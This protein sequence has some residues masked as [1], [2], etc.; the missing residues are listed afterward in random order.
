MDQVVLALGQ[1]RIVAVLLLAVRLS[2]VLLLT[3]VLHAAAMPPMVRVL[4]V[5]GLACAMAL[6]FGAQR[7]AEGR[8]VAWLVQAVLREAVV[9]ATL[10]LGILVAF[11]GFS[12]AGR[13]ID[14][15][16]GF[17]F[18]QVLD[19]VTR[20]QV[21][22]LSAT[23]ALF[24]AVVFFLV[25]GH[26]ALLRGVAYSLERFPLGEPFSLAGAVEPVTRQAAAL[27]AL[28]FA[29]AAPVVLVLLLVEFAL[30]AVSRNLPQM[31]MLALGIPVKIL[32]GL[33]ALS[34]WAAGFG[35]PAG[36]LYAEIYKAWTGWFAAERS[37]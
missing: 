4:I 21:P 36:R 12:V 29:L 35:A 3:P 15:Q 17:G 13:L 24:A 25:D 23:F 18:A 26:H 27:F 33:V 16:V 8:D 1:D 20:V 2:A 7:M 37:R 28:G 5:L 30:G 9:G 32:V 19:P 14:V 10:G 6:P 31:S 11:A 22:A 34:V